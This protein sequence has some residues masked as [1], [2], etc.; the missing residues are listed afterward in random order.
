M[1][2]KKNLALLILIISNLTTFAQDQITTE[3][4]TLND[5]NEFDK[6]IEQ[7]ASKSLDYSAKSLYYIGLAYYMKEDDS[8]CI[9]F[10]NLSIDK[11]SKDPASFYI[12]A[13]TL[14][15]MQKYDEAVKNFQSA[16]NLKSDDAEFYS[17]LGDSYYNL[18]KLDLD[19]E[20]YKKAT[21]QKNC[22]AR[23][24]R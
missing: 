21:E 2:I 12:K 11:D 7:H 1:A 22:P 16:I 8:N 17:G 5:N 4:K 13:S 23:E 3:L 9:K 24:T 19:L 6:I 14:N 18:K 20:A 10:M 15:Y